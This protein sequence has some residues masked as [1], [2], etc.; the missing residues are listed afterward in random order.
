VAQQVVSVT[1]AAGQQAL[2]LGRI[3]VPTQGVPQVG[4][5]AANF[6]F[7]GPDGRETDLATQRGKPVLV[8]FWATWC[9]PCVAKLGEVDALRNEY[10]KDGRLVVVGANLDAD[11]AAA[12]KFLKER[13][14]AW[15]HAFLGDWSATG[16]P[17]QYGITSVPA[18][19]LVDR[20]GKIAAI[21]YSVEKLSPV[22]KAVLGGRAE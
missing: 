6:K 7:I 3:V 21:E 9:G 8:D 15:H 4:D 22:L 11:Q 18:Y 1:V 2:D 10:A 13:P 16:V 20:E 14:L 5:P 19:V 17:R 12:E